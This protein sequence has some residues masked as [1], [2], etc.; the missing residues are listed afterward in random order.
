MGKQK[1]KHVQLA[2]GAAVVIAI[3]NAGGSF[4]THDVITSAD[5][6][7]NERD[8]PFNGKR[9]YLSS[10]T[11]ISSGSRGELG[12][13]ENINGRH[14]NAYA[15]NGD[16]VGGQLSIARGRS[17]S[18]R[19]YR[20]I[21]SQN[22]RNGGFINNRNNSD[23]WGADVH[24]ATHTNAG[25]GDYMLVM[26]DDETSTS[27]DQRLR[28]ELLL[29]VGSSAAPYNVYVELLFHDN[30]THVDWLGSG[31]DWGRAVKR[32]AWRYGWAVDR[33]LGYP[34]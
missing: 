2:A 12:W 7:Y 10:P 24:I 23:N 9:I 28:S 4:A 20:V 31:S 25:R 18:S 19:G 29:R 11:H 34:N 32:H 26:I 16:F 8:V 15:A 17:L 6:T 5:R 22:G 1:L 33:A 3:F 30:Q 13:E 21:V 14:W 27:L